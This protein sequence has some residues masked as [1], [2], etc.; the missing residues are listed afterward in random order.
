MGRN[1]GNIRG[2]GNKG[3]HNLVFERIAR[4]SIYS[5]LGYNPKMKDASYTAVVPIKKHISLNTSL[6]GSGNEV[7]EVIGIKNTL[8]DNVVY[9]INGERKTTNF[10]FLA[11][12]E[13]MKLIRHLKRL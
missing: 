3:D 11:K 9:K 4:A 5:H 13:Q 6:F 8:N 1:S 7:G 12:S 2:G 10:S